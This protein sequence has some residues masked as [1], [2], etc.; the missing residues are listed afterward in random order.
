MCILTFCLLPVML[1]LC[2]LKWVSLWLDTLTKILIKDSA[3]FLVIWGRMTHWQWMVCITVFVY[4]GLAINVYYTLLCIQ[5]WNSDFWILT[6]Q[7]CTCLQCDIYLTFGSGLSHSSRRYISTLHPTS[8]CSGETRVEGQRCFISTG[9]MKS[10][11]LQK[12]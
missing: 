2:R 4:T 1:T 5:Q 11:H 7:W 9:L 12:D 6:D 3:V 8:S 10:G